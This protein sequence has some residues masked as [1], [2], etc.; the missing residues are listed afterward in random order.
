LDI[1]NTYV[2]TLSS[3]ITSVVALLDPETVALGGGVSLAGDFLFEPLRK[4]VKQKS[5]FKILHEIVPAKFGNKAGIIGASLL[6]E[7]REA[8]RYD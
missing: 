3:A 1:F 6:A 8:L 4:L 2:D 5:F 7:S